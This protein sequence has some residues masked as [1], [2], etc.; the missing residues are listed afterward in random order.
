MNN[1]LLKVGKIESGIP[2]PEK[3]RTSHTPYPF[4]E[5]AIGDSFIVELGDQQEK[6][7]KGRLHNA[8]RSFRLKNNQMNFAIL[9]KTIDDKTIRVWRTG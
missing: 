6:L 3:T 4:N 7:V 9:I 2:I 8:I 5:M 1:R